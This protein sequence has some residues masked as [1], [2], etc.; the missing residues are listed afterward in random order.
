MEYNAPLP[1]TPIDPSV[2]PGPTGK[3][4]N[5]LLNRYYDEGVEQ[6]S[7][8]FKEMRQ[9]IRL[10]T[11]KQLY[12][13]QDMGPG[14]RAGY[15]KSSGANEL[16]IVL[17]HIPRIAGVYL[18]EIL[19]HAPDI[20]VTVDDAGN[21]GAAR[22]AKMNQTVWEEHKKKSRLYEEKMRLEI[23]N[24]IITGEI[25]VKLYWDSEKN[26]VKEEPILPFDLLR[27]PGVTDIGDSPWYIHRKIYREE[28]L[29]KIYGPQTGSALADEGQSGIENTD[30]LVFSSQSR[31]FS[32]FRGV[33]IREFYLRPNVE[34]PQGYFVFYMRD[35]ILQEG[36]LPGGIFPIVIRRLQS[37]L[38]LPRGYSFI[39][40][41][42]A[43][44][45]EINRAMSQDA[46]NMYHFGGDKI[47]TGS[48]SSISVGE[49][50][51][52]TSHLKVGGYGPLRDSFLYVE[53]SGIPKY[54]DYVVFLI[55]Q[56]DYQVNLQTKMEEKKD[57]R[58]GDIQFVLY[59][60]IRDKERFATIGTN[61]EGYVREKAE[62]ILSL[63]RYY[64]GPDDIIHEGNRE[65]QVLIEDFKQTNDR[66]YVFSIKSSSGSAE[67]R[68]AKQ[69][70]AQSAFQY[71]GKEMTRTDKGMF[72]SHTSMANDK[73]LIA[74]YTSDY[75]SAKNDMISLEKG[76]MPYIAKTMD[77]HYKIQ[78]LT[79]RMNKADFGYLYP[80]I[81]QNYEEFLSICQQQLAEMEEERLRL[82]K[83]HIPMD[84]PL[85]KTDY[86]VK[87]PD[88]RGGTK[89]ER[90][91]LPGKSIVWLKQ[92][93]D[94]Q[95]GFKIDMEGLPLDSQNEIIGQMPAIDGQLSGGAAP[96]VV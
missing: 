3:Y 80:H 88:T 67:D 77:F 50:F 62:C 34:H 16:K 25:A 12:G 81:R 66:D 40:T 96:P 92:V 95:Q 63:L 35:R 27:A 29:R 78:K 51:R 79:E 69:Y 89:T 28:E 53:G 6:D 10:H 68:L 85:V 75:D 36:P 65:D 87:M 24:G 15:S 72:L 56:M 76:I 2:S 64:L 59:S 26:W 46:S 93:L 57:A 37:S 55:K 73:E 49:S 38:M 47:V 18:N 42:T 70:L 30:Y 90:L 23:L 82:E 58:S 19:S 86:L 43:T 11:G 71:L 52:G 22:L 45:M 60:R 91:S 74:S 21:I 41:V 31:E 54:M 4:T 5:D 48:R 20:T 44:Q 13:G 39:R 1:A 14:G 84:G 32:A 83:N 17:N 33:E 94:K 7:Q 8:A 9:C 61:Y